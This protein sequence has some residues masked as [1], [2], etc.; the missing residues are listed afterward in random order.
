MEVK[1]SKAEKF[2]PS[3]PENYD[4]KPVPQNKDIYNMQP[5]PANA[6]PQPQQINLEIPGEKDNVQRASLE[7]YDEIWFPKPSKVLL[8]TSCCC[9]FYG[10]TMQWPNCN[11]QSCD[12][13]FLW[14][15]S[16]CSQKWCQCQEPSSRACWKCN[17]SDALI[18]CSTRDWSLSRGSLACVY[19]CCFQ[20]KYTHG[21]NMIPTLLKCKSQYYC[22]AWACAIP[23]APTEIPFEIACCGQHCLGQNPDFKESTTVQINVNSPPP[24]QPAPQ[25]HEV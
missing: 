2:M 8:R 10:F 5:A 24:A 6:P 21:I 20:C 4:E 12:C 1:K 23:F 16:A 9:C 11:G 14:C 22:Y 17:C 7:R 25:Q 19:C 18:D 13:S 15:R 3:A